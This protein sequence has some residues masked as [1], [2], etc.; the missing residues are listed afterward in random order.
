MSG[1]TPH[2]LYHRIVHDVQSA[3]TF[4]PSKL[5]NAPLTASGDRALTSTTSIHPVW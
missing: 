1:A 3:L 5:H 2:Y 4:L